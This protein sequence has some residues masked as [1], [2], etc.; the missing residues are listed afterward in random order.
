MEVERRKDVEV[1]GRKGGRECRIA[2]GCED[3]K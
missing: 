1:E 2:H 3:E